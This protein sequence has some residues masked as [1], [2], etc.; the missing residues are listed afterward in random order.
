MKDRDVKPSY[1]EHLYTKW[2]VLSLEKVSHN[3]NNTLSEWN[4]MINSLN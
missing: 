3:Q 4:W 2:I 1:S